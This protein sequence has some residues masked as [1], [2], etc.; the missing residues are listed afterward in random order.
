MEC[1]PSLLSMNESAC[2]NFSD[3]IDAGK[4]L[5][6]KHPS[7]RNIY[8]KWKLQPGIPMTCSRAC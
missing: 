1:F 6:L 5:Y 4:L 3:A 8:R 2:A 7:S